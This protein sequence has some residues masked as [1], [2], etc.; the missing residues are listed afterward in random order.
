MGYSDGTC[1]ICSNNG[2]NLEHVLLNCESLV[3]IWNR[4][5][6][7]VE[8]F[9]MDSDNV[10]FDKNSDVFCG[11]LRANIKSDLVNCLLSIIRWTIWKRRCTN[12]Y[13]NKLIN[14][15]ALK[16]WINTEIYTHIQTLKK[17]KLCNKIKNCIKEL[18]ILET[19]IKSTL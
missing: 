2:E 14:V 13:E 11:I 10:F 7:I 17:T 6:V 16:K 9:D 18:N 1:S 3:E 19:I 4:V 5:E 12:K 15:T 8:K